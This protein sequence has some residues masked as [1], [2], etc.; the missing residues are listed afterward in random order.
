MNRAHAECASPL[1]TDPMGNDRTYDIVIVGAGIVGA[2]LA[3]ELSAYAL[4]IA[5]I[6][7]ASDIPSGASRANSA[8]AASSPVAASA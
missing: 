1:T 4:R 5:V 2:A 6:D 8:C 7:K 3:R